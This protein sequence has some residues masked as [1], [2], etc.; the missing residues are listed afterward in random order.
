MYFFNNKIF[1]QNLIE[2]EIDCPPF[3]CV[4]SISDI[5][6]LLIGFPVQERGGEEWKRLIIFTEEKYLF[7]EYR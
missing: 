4:S 2:I 1:R 3:D 7:K 6:F 5:S